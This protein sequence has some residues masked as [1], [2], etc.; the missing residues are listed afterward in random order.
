MTLLKRLELAPRSLHMNTPEKKQEM[1]FFTDVQEIRRRAR[2]HMERGPI[3]PSYGLDVSRVIEILNQAL[4]TEIV[5]VLRYRNHAYMAD[6]IHAK[7]VAEE[8][9]EHATEE[10]EHADRLARRIRELGGLP[11][12]NPEGLLTRS[13]STYQTSPSL[14]QMMQEDLYAE[15]IAIE[16]YREIIR[17]L[18]EQDPTTRRLMEEILAKEE[19]HADDLASLLGSYPPS[20]EDLQA[21]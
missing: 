1:P 21:A 5:C 7:S 15:R 9:E 8:F 18:G 16:S 11:D 13:H 6:G 14:R 20:Q 4:A 3:T 10:A 12:L 19:E 17:F 2:A